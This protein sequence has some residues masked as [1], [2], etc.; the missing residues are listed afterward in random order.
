MP[1]QEEREVVEVI[2][3]AE[4]NVNVVNSVFLFLISQLFP[5]IYCFL[6]FDTL[7]HDEFRL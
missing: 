7:V 4:V 1:A 2:T 3:E 6:M 5:S